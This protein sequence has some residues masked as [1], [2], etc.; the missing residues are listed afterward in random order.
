MIE[1]GVRSHGGLEAPVARSQALAASL[2]N[3]PSES[4]SSAVLA[5]DHHLPLTH[6]LLELARPLSSQAARSPREWAGDVRSV[7]HLRYGMQTSAPQSVCSA[8]RLLTQHKA[9]SPRTSRTQTYLV[10]NM[11]HGLAF[12][13]GARCGDG[14]AGPYP[15]RGRRRE[16]AGT[17]YVRPLD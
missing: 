10:A 6:I 4:C 15:V 3:F 5:I 1:V 7:V 9:C 12:L 8:V 17:Q 11:H 14:V 13:E 2:D 16:I